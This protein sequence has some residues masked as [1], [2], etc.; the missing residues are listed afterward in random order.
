[1]ISVQFAV[2][3][4]DKKPS[5][6]QAN[7]QKAGEYRVQGSL[8][9]MTVDHVHEILY[10]SSTYCR[11]HATKV[12][13]HHVQNNLDVSY[14]MLR[15]PP[16]FN[17]NAQSGI[18]GY[19]GHNSADGSAL[20]KLPFNGIDTVGR[21]DKQQE[22]RPRRCSVVVGVLSMLLITGLSRM[23]QIIPYHRHRHRFQNHSYFSNLLPLQNDP[24]LIPSINSWCGGCFRQ[25]T[26]Q[27]LVVICSQFSYGD[28]KTYLY[29]YIKQ[30]P[31]TDV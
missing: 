9:K 28:K 13:L 26:K 16:V 22:P 2:S 14:A 3:Q 10:Y 31:V 29:T 15:C 17:K 19:L 21:L 24:T 20:G 8:R 1:M 7:P 23:I 25:Y 11:T 5:V 18:P 12:E 30:K 4:N 6:L 27:L